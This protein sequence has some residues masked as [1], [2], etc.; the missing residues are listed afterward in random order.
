MKTEN[1]IPFHIAIRLLVPVLGG[2]VAR[3]VTAISR[4]ELLYGYVLFTA[5]LMLGW[6]L[7]LAKSNYIFVLHVL[8]FGYLMM[9]CST[10][11]RE[12]DKNLMLSMIFVAAAICIGTFAM[13]T[14]AFIERGMEPLLLYVPLTI[15]AAIT[16]F[17]RVRCAVD[18]M[19]SGLDG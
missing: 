19:R 6:V 18:D 9:A 13:G 15:G 8:E 17:G 11:Y 3:R 12:S 5:A 16:L 7:M 2:I 1:K 10:I 14:G 4:V